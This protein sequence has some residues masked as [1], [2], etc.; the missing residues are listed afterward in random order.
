M[1]KVECTCLECGKVFLMS[2]HRLKLGWGKYCSKPCSGKAHKTL[3]ECT[4]LICGSTF[5]RKPSAIERGGGKY[6]SRQCNNL[7]KIKD[8][9]VTCLSCGK[10]FKQ[11]HDEKYCSLKCVGVAHTK[12]KE[13]CLY[14]G[15][16]YKRHGSNNNYCS[17]ECYFKSREHTERVC[18]NCG[19][20][21]R[22]IKQGKG[23][24]CSKTCAGLAH[25]KRVKATCLHCGKEFEVI[26][27]HSDI[28]NGK[29]CSKICANQSRKL[30]TG[31]RHPSWKG[32]KFHS[33]GLNWKQQQR[34]AYERD[35][36]ICQHCG[37]TEKQ[38]LKKYHRKNAIH[39]IEKRR[40][41]RERGESVEKSSVLTNL[42]C[43]C[44]SCHMLAEHSK[45]ILKPKL[46]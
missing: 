41:F 39:H 35:G 17:R 38:A 28:N 21:Y 9:I 31:E 20:T 22:P 37:L 5:T 24:Y 45:I 8:K 26:P 30:I 6:C 1:A 44:A 16:E 18:L 34:L 32:G 40:A 23:V 14:C 7:S 13:N 11:K 2:A 10:S 33:Y 29:Y 36:G 25:R 46:L 15:R 3:V 42:I 27:S 12:P 43:L 19:I 4:C